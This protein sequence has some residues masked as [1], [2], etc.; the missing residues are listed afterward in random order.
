MDNRWL[1]P[2]KREFQTE[3]TF[4][5]VMQAYV[6]ITEEDQIDK[7]GEFK[8]FGQSMEPDEKSKIKMLKL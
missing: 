3:Q 7:S 6:P 1:T 4:K 2:K 8:E 5:S